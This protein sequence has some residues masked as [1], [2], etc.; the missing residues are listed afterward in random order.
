MEVFATLDDGRHVRWCE[1]DVRLFG[2]G[3]KAKA[4]RVRTVIGS[5][6]RETLRTQRLPG[7]PLQWPGV[8]LQH[9]RGVPHGRPPRLESAAP[10]DRERFAASCR[11]FFAKAPRPPV[12]LPA[13][14]PATVVAIADSSC[15]L[16]ALLARISNSDGV[17][18]LWVVSLSSDQD[19]G[20]TSHNADRMRHARLADLV[21]ARGF[22]LSPGSAEPMCSSMA[23]A[24]RR[25]TA[26]RV[27]CEQV[28]LPAR[29]GCIR[30]TF[31]PAA[32]RTSI[33]ISRAPSV[34][35]WRWSTTTRRGSPWSG[36]RLLPASEGCAP[37]R[38]AHRSQ[39]F[40]CGFRRREH[41]SAT[42]QVCCERVASTPTVPNPD[43][44]LTAAR[45][46]SADGAAGAA[47]DV[48]VGP[49]APD[50]ALPYVKWSSSVVDVGGV[51]IVIPTRDR[52]PLL[53]RCVESLRDTVDPAGVRLLIVD[54]R[55]SEAATRDYLDRLERDGVFGC[56]VLRPS[57]GDQRFNYAR[58]MNAAA[59]V[60]Q[61]P[62]MLH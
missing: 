6:L 37:M 3:W 50:L 34:R 57:V 54:D 61:T 62:V 15:G 14:D 39:I 18:E 2:D 23:A 16:Q 10:F 32:A 5:A 35:N 25:R 24:F 41:Q 21:D 51:T 52:L 58:L 20:S 19:V 48:R 43:H 33:R 22:W 4:G 26:C 30:M 1:R 13:L 8:L 53:R 45:A 60:V 9:W 56:A 7:S 11:A 27:Q 12:A 44:R 29:T 31:S 46:L 36:A 28:S 38:G 59:D 42:V 47:I 17:H 40:C 49:N 55:S